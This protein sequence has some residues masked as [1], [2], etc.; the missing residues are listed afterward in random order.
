VNDPPPLKSQRAWAR[1]AVVAAILLVYWPV[2]GHRME[3]IDDAMNLRSN[4]D[5][6]PP[7]LASVARYWKASAFDLYAP[8]TF[9]VWGAIAS[10]SHRPELPKDQQLIAWPF[11]AVNLLVHVLS[12]L[13]V[14]QL[15]L[16]LS[17]SVVA[18][19]LGALAFALHPLAVESVAWASGLKDTL[20]GMLGLSAVLVY[21]DSRGS[22][23]RYILSCV[24]LILSM[25][26]KP[27]AIIVPGIALTL[28][29]FTPSR[30]F[31]PTLVRWA[32]WLVLTFPFLVMA[33]RAQPATQ[34]A[35]VSFPNKI[36]I[37]MDSLGFYLCKLA[38]PLRL[39]SDYGRTPEVVW[40]RGWGTI[41]WIV[42]LL[43][44]AICVL[45]FRKTSKP[46]TCFILFT[47]ALAPMLGLVPF[48][49]QAYSTVADHYAYLALLSAALGVAWLAA[50]FNRRTIRWTVA[51]L[52]LTLALLT[53]GQVW[54]WR[55]RATISRQMLV[56]NPTSWVAHLSLG[57]IALNE[58]R[59]E[60]ALEHARRA[61]EFKPETSKTHVLLGQAQAASGHYPEAIAALRQAIA[62]APSDM[63]A[64]VGLA[65]A[66]ADAGDRQ[67]AIQQYLHALELS[68]N[69][70]VAASNLASVYAETGDLRQALRWYDWALANDPT[71]AP[72]RAGRER[73]VQRLNGL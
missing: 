65:D 44:G 8:V 45:L 56:A 52:C 50:H 5:F 71:F 51:G 49:Y 18:A 20:A 36:R 32:P 14:L 25:L 21:V 69:D 42:P 40:A 7:T 54:T 47:L 30:P 12:A 64:N 43:V 41:M 34:I 53:H 4:R 59:A 70:V 55:D 27:S 68:P 15:L 72:A 6:N 10:I 46:L 73:V 31:K 2:L 28:D 1:I 3:G 9:S 16:R 67:A 17:D 19:M 29:L 37:A 23:P 66:L 61:V 58:N 57:Q 38:W 62:L 24:L 13:V 22:L 35:P 33:R 39:G 63:S 60:E 11:Y 26:A 48:D